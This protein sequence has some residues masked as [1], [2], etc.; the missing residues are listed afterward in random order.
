MTDRAWSVSDF[1]LRA[2]SPAPYYA[3]GRIQQLGHHQVVRIGPSRQ[4]KRHDER[5]AVPQW[6]SIE[7]TI[8]GTFH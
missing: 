4:I 7:E 6:V 5:T 3:V 2:N 8:H 1:R